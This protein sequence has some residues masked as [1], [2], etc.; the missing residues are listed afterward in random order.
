MFFYLGIG[1][2]WKVK[3]LGNWSL[4]LFNLLENQAFGAGLASF[5]SPERV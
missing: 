5:V 4:G 3:F 1:I 2:F